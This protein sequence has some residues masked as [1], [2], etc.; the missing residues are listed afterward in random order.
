M[1]DE[2]YASLT[3]EE[4]LLEYLTFLRN[5]PDLISSEKH[6]IVKTVEK[7]LKI[8][9]II[10]DG[11]KFEFNSLIAKRKTNLIDFLSIKLGFSLNILCPPVKECI[12][13]QR[14]LSINNRPTQVVVYKLTGPEIYSKYIYRCKSCSLVKKSKDKA[15]NK[16][17]SQDIYYH[18]NQFGNLKMVGY[19]TK[20]VPKYSCV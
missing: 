4:I 9:E 8:D 10:K 1:F 15:F 6:K 18:I 7:A 3:R 13:C 19:F 16:G 17:K 12:L 5:L 2:I 11:T 20:K 14:N